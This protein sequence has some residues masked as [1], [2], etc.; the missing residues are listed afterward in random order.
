VRVRIDA[1]SFSANGEIDASELDRFIPP[2]RMSPNGP[3]R[4]DISREAGTLAIEGTLKSGGGSGT[5]TF[6]P[7]QTFI[8]GL[9]ARGFARPTAQ[10]LFALAQTTSGLRSSTIAAQKYTRPDIADLVRAAQ[11]AWTSSSC[12][13]WPEGP[14]PR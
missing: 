8:A 9:T 5:F 13:K 10:Q 3:I 12:A 1:G 2:L 6:T 11:P 4:F 14:S 7:S